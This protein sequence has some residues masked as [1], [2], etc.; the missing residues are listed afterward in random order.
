MAIDLPPELVPHL[1]NEISDFPFS[2]MTAMGPS[3]PPRG[4]IISRYP[5]P[6]EIQS[7]EK[8]GCGCQQAKRAI[9]TEKRLW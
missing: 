6:F 7:Q 8:G 5:T 2:F 9:E 3:D 4:Q 1:C